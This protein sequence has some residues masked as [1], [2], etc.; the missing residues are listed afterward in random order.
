[1]PAYTADFFGPKN[2]GAN[3]GLV[4]S[5]WGLCGF[6]VPGYFAGIMDRARQAGDL[7]AGY[8]EVYWKLAVIALA[9]AAAAAMLRPP[10]AE[11]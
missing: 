2:V 7:A 5:A 10:R 6:L 3:Y 1:M 11:S 9:G 4:F 8:N